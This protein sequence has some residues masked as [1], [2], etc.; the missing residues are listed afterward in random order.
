LPT[1][2]GLRDSLRCDPVPEFGRSTPRG[3]AGGARDSVA[4]LPPAPS[5]AVRCVSSYVAAPPGSPARRFLSE[6]RTQECHRSSATVKV[7]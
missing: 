4:A 6:S 7:R 3:R 1:A 5:G 2:W